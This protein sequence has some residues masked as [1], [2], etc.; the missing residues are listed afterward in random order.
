M[1]FENLSFG[2][3]SRLVRNLYEND[4]HIIASKY[5]MSKAVIQMF[6]SLAHLRNTCA[7][8]S[9]VWN[10]GFTIKVSPYKKYN[11]TFQEIR[12][13]SLFA[14]IIVIQIFIKKIDP[15]SAWLDKLNQLIEEYDVDIHRMGFSEDWLD[16][17]QFIK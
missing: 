17:L 4:R 5:R 16:R 1:F 8:H 2:K 7:H 9:R 11:D 13:D 3:C 12:T 14:Y 10:R 6:H 15:T